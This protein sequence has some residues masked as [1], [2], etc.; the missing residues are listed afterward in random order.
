MPF[1]IF[2]GPTEFFVWGGGRLKANRWTERTGGES[3]KKQFQKPIKDLCGN[4][5]TETAKG[6]QHLSVKAMA[7]NHFYILLFFMN[8]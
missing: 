4:K 7:N 6:K 8:L 1:S 3:L 2:Q 5:D